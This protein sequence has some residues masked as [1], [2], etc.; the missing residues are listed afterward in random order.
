MVRT[1]IFVE[2]E[3][4]IL[5]R[6]LIVSDYI[7]A[8]NYGGP[9][10]SMVNLIEECG[11]EFEF[12]VLAQNHDFNSKK[13]L[14]GIKKGINKVGKAKVIYLNDEE[15]NYSNIKKIVKEIEPDIIYQNSIFHIKFC[16]PMLFLSKIERIPLI[17]APRGELCNNAF[18]LG[19]EKKSI[20]LCI[21][22]KL[23]LLK[24]T[25]F[26]VT[27]E[28]E[29]Y[30]VMS[31]L[32]AVPHKVKLIEN[33][34]TPVD[35]PLLRRSKLNGELKVLF[36]SRIQRKKNLKYAIQLVNELTSNIKFDIYG[37]IEDKLYWE[38]CLSEI[39]KAPEN[40]QI[41][42]RGSVE[43]K[44]IYN[45][46]PN[47]HVLFLPT[48]SENYGHVIVE[49]MLYGCPVIISDQ[50]PWTDINNH[51]SGFA[52]PLSNRKAFTEKLDELA[53]MNSQQY[54]TLVDNCLNYILNKIGSNNLKSL[55]IDMFNY[56]ENN[57]DKE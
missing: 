14:E 42:Y 39:Q 7:P 9:V 55:Y 28:E 10:V 2:G 29:K 47:Y 30:S 15:V 34:P 35:T 1:Y 49:S 52:F 18:N 17:L 46:Y 6:V 27:S 5:Q 37:P 38:E 20:Y 12:Y 57:K 50:T 44:D 51:N 22:K 45:I 21:L 33:I 53:S 13:P 8:E 19:K 4:N 23:N 40:I 11:D 32:D 56:V 24:N 54:N 31:R 3:K 43:H 36:I 41:R 26:H 48:L 16:L 25:Y